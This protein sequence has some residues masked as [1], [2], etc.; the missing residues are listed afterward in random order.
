[1]EA[2]IEA[3]ESLGLSEQEARLLCVETVRRGG[4]NGGF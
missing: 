4:L 1:M 2:M 3:A